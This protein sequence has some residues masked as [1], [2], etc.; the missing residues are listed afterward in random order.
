MNPVL[1]KLEYH[2]DAIAE[3][4]AAY[5]WYEMKEPG[6]GEKFQRQ[7]REKLEQI[8]QM[9]EAFSVKSRRQY[10]EAFVDK[11]PY[12]ITYKIYSAKHIVFVS[13]LHHQKKH[14]D[15]KYR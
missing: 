2:P 8:V 15:K 13:S 11:F 4:E 5:I 7:V 6:L 14:P 9:P 12:T 3:Y 10:R 1:F